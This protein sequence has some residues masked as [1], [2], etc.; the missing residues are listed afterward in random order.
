MKNNSFTLFNETIFFFFFRTRRSG[1]AMTRLVILFWLSI[2]TASYADDTI[3]PPGI[4]MV[5]KKPRKVREY[6]IAHDAR[7]FYD[8]IQH[9]N[10]FID[11]S[12]LIK[13]VLENEIIAILIT[14]PAGWGKSINLDMLRV[15]FEMEVDADG[16]EY[17]PKTT[18][19]SYQL[20]SEAQITW[21]DKLNHRLDTPLLISYHKDIINGHLGRYPVVSVNMTRIIGRTR[22][23]VFCNIG[24]MLQEVFVKHRYMLK[25]LAKLITDENETRTQR[26]KAYKN[27][28][29]F[30][31]FVE[32][33]QDNTTH[34]TYSIKFICSVLFHHFQKPVVVLVDDYDAAMRTVLHLDRVAIPEIVEILHV[35]MGIIRYAT[36]NNVFL[37]RAILVG[38]LQFGKGSHMTPCSVIE[39]NYIH[40]NLYYQY[41]G[42]HQNEINLLFDYFNMPLELRDQT[43]MWYN[44]FESGFHNISAHIYNPQPI[45]EL[46][47]TKRLQNTIPSRLN[48]SIIEGAI[49]LKPFRYTFE[50]LINYRNVT[51]S[52]ERLFLSR[53]DMVNFAEMMNGTLELLRCSSIESLLTYLISVGY[54]TLTNHRSY[55]GGF[56]RRILEV[57]VPNKEIEMDLIDKLIKVYKQEIN[58]PLELID[59][60]AVKLVEFVLN[61]T[62]TSRDLEVTLQKV[63]ENL[64]VFSV[65]HNNHNDTT[66]TAN[67]SFL[68]SLFTYILIRTRTLFNF[69][70][71]V[72][73]EYLKPTA[74]MYRGTRAA[75]LK[76]R[77]NIKTKGMAVTDSSKVPTYKGNFIGNNE[78]TAI[79]FIA[80]D[81]FDDKTVAILAAMQSKDYDDYA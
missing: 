44:G 27:Y 50:S 18:S 67:R 78:I 56:D 66:Y 81:I 45:V 58:T 73:D 72:C 26:R 51:L 79:K 46:I 69:K 74:I 5:I 77:H 65:F 37:K 16:Q 49:Q 29:K 42:F 35:C 1:F 70:A 9:S 59:D 31:M 30:K 6:P 22:D 23:E 39:Y 8:L 55:S 68:N 63:F 4:Q 40:N 15:F 25:I 13:D 80:I 64:P 24:L 33:T 48:L 34:I 17:Y 75:T 71:N 60:A 21:N 36:K 20:F 38:R 57:K 53:Y 14:C 41:F 3:S 7:T 11:K 76:V 19:V 54:L 32:N 12:L 2:V 47:A 43:R 52:F 61:D 10:V 28:E 62:T